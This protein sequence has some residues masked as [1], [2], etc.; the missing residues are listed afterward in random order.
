MIFTSKRIHS[1]SRTLRLTKTKSRSSSLRMFTLRSELY[2]FV[3]SVRCCPKLTIHLYSLP[4]AI[5]GPSVLLKHSFDLLICLCW[6]GEGHTLSRVQTIFDYRTPHLT[7]VT[8][9][10]FYLF[11]GIRPYLLSRMTYKESHAFLSLFLDI[12][13]C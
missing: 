6:V 10:F 5:C 4:Y 2:S 8:F 13:P 11:P 12:R 1:N 3:L 9:F 7:S